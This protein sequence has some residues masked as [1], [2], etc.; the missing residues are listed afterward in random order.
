MKA[1]NEKLDGC[2][3]VLKFPPLN[4]NV[5]WSNGWVNFRSTFWVGAL[6]SSTST[7]SKFQTSFC[8]QLPSSKIYK[9]WEKHC[10]SGETVII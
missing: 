5:G 10:Q 9:K 8:R 3:S 4:Q 6:T 1:N 7:R 2:S